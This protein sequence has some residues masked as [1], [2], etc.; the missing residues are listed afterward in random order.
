[1]SKKHPI[2]LLAHARDCLGRM[3][4]YAAEGETFFLRDRKTQDAI[5]RNLEI[6]GQCIK[7]AGM[8]TLR[9]AHPAV[10]WRTTANF[11]NVLAHSYQSVKPEM[12][13]AVV[14]IQVTHPLNTLNGI[15]EN[16]QP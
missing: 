7:D 5:Y 2:V 13:W 10:G 14:E 8:D 1:M 11:R 4:D 6:V 12:V 16:W 3:P 9:S 15:L